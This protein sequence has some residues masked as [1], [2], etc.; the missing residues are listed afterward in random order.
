MSMN[1][2]GPLLRKMEATFDNN[3]LDNKSKLLADGPTIEELV[4]NINY[5]DWPNVFA[6]LQYCVENGLLLH[7]ES[8]TLP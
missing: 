3:I 2:L 5:G 4:H 7:W 8:P 1:C 6:R